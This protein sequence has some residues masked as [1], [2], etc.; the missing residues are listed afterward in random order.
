MCQ[1][2]DIAALLEFSQQQDELIDG[3]QKEM[4]QVLA[5][6]RHLRSALAQSQAQVKQQTEEITK[7]KERVSYLEAENEQ[8][9]NRPQY[10]V[11]QYVE[12]QKVER[13]YLMNPI[14]K[15]TKKIS[16][17]SNQLPIWDQNASFM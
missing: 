14:R 15:R 10:N 6:N 17:S 7:L 4:K 2:D 8:M 12:K 3:H 16:T 5:N 13:Q 11:K 9:R 1:D